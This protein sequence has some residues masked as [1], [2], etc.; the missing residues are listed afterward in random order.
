MSRFDLD[1][2]QCEVGVAKKTVK[3]ATKLFLDWYW[4]IFIKIET[5]VGDGLKRSKF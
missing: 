1:V 5:D 3:Y 2:F 4:K